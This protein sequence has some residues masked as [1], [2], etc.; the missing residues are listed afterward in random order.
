MQSKCNFIFVFQASYKMYPLKRGLACLS[1]RTPGGLLWAFC[2]NKVL[3][4]TLRANR[5]QHSCL[6]FSPIAAGS[7]ACRNLQQSSLFF[8]THSLPIQHQHFLLTAACFTN[9]LHN[10]PPLE[11]YCPPRQSFWGEFKQFQ[12]GC[13][14]LPWS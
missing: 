6:V 10:N 14:F 3:M 5:S 4:D 8:L 12:T 1:W 9:S 11:F 7:A 2:C 13:L